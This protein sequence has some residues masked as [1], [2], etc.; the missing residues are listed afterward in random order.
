MNDQNNGAI[1]LS[2]AG[3]AACATIVLSIMFS[4]MN[5]Y[6]SSPWPYLFLPLAIGSWMWTVHTAKK[7]GTS[8]LWVASVLIVDAG[9]ATA[10]AWSSIAIALNPSF[11]KYQVMADEAYR[12]TGPGLLPN[13]Q[14]D[15]ML[16]MLAVA[17]LARVI[18]P[19]RVFDKSKVDWLFLLRWFALAGAAILSI[20]H[21][22]ANVPTQV[23]LPILQFTAIAGLVMKTVF[24]MATTTKQSRDTADQVLR[25]SKLISATDLAAQIRARFSGK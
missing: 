12:L 11:Q 13:L 6:T 24:V 21:L 8:S 16:G 5:E 2:I 23:W 15:A 7:H 1:K 3:L 10:F 9:I 25:G 22:R 14:M 20:I 17:A 19:G 4:H 18:V